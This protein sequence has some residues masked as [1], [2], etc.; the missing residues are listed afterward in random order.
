MA[1]FTH[2]DGFA[3]C[4]V[5]PSN[6]RAEIVVVEGH[7]GMPVSLRWSWAI[8]NSAERAPWTR[9]WRSSPAQGRVFINTL[10]L[11][12]PCETRLSANRRRAVVDGGTHAEGL[13]GGDFERHAGL[14]HEHGRA[15]AATYPQTRAQHF[16]AG[17]RG[18]DE[19]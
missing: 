13:V 15:V 6:Q 8:N 16:F 3:E 2:R 11:V 17:F 1:P 7:S 18:H 5:G 12:K 14:G 19:T 4:S 9:G 10:G